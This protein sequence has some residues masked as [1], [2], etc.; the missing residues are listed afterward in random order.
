MLLILLIQFLL[1]TSVGQTWVANQATSFL[2]EKLNTV[3]SI[4]KVDISFFKF[5]S[6]DQI[7][8]EDLNQ[9]TLFYVQTIKAEIDFWDYSKDSLS[10]NFGNVE[11]QT[12]LYYLTQNQGDSITNITHLFAPLSSG[13]NSDGK[14]HLHIEANEIFVN[15]GRFIWNNYNEPEMDFG[16]NWDHIGL[17]SINGHFEDFEMINDSFNAYIHALSGKDVSGFE[18]TNLSGKAIF[19]S[20]LTQLEELSLI[21]QNSNIQ[22][23][24][25][26]N[27]DSITSYASFIDQVYMYYSIDSSII[28]MTDISYFAP[29][30]QGLDYELFVHGEEKG[31]VSDMKFNNIFISYGE[32]TI[33]DGRVFITGLPEIENT[34]FNCNFRNLS[35]NYNDLKS[36]KTYPFN[37][38]QTVTVPLF[39]KNAKGINF[40]GRFN[41]FYNDF[42]TYGTFTSA[43]GIVKT[44]LKL[45]QEE[46]GKILYDGKIKTNDFRLDALFNKNNLL[47][48][49]SI[50]IDVE[51]ENLDFN[52]MKLKMVGTASSFDFK[53][54]TYKN[55]KVNGEI[56]DK[57]LSGSLDIIDT[58]LRLDFDGA[59]NLKKD[60]PRYEFIAQVDHLKPKQ[61]NLMDRDTSASV[62][63]KVIFNFKG[64]NLDNVVGR[65][66]L[67]DFHFTEYDRKVDLKNVE[68]LA[69]NVGDDK[70]LS[71]KS[72]NIDL[73][74]NGQFNFNKISQSFNSIIYKWIPSAFSKKPVKPNEIQNFEM[75]M[76][77]KRF[78]GFSSIFIPQI[79]FESDL[80]IG[81][82][83][84]S[85]DEE[86][87]LNSNSSQL[88]IL[89]KPVHNFELGAS[90]T[91]DTLD[92]VVNSK[93]VNF[94]DSNF[95]ENVLFTASAHEDLINTHTSWNNS[96][97]ARDDSANIY[98]DILFTDPENF[99][100]NSRHSWIV[101]NDS[102]WEL[103]DSSEVI[104]QK[105]EYT[106]N[107]VLISQNDQHIRVNGA[108]S[109]NPEKSLKL[110]ID[111]LGLNVLNPLLNKYSINTEGTLRGTTTINDVYNEIGLTSENYF[112][113]LIFNDQYIGNGHILSK[114]NA[115]I[116][117][118][119]LMVDFK[120]EELDRLELLGTYI[121]K[122]KENQLNIDLTLDEFPVKIIEPFAEG[123]IDNVKGTISGESKIR[124]TIRHPLFDGRFKV[125]DIETR[126]IYL[127]ETLSITNEELFIR[128]TLIG[129]D[130]IVVSDQRGKKAQLNF[131]L[132]HNNFENIN[133]DLSCTSIDIFR[134]FNTER[135]DNDY[136]YGEVYLDPGSTVGIESDYEGNVSINAELTSG[137]QSF[138]TIPFYE[139]SEVSQR[140][141]IYF[142]DP[143]NTSDSLSLNNKK[144]P[145]AFGLNLDMNMNL[146]ENAEVQLIFDE[147]TN[148]NIRATGNG[149]IS[150]KI[151]ETDFNI[152]GTYEISKG[153]YLFTFSNIISKKFEIK[154]NSKLSWNGDPY[155]GISDIE[156]SYK[157]RTSLYDLGITLDSSKSRI[158]VEVVLNMTG[159]YMNPDLAFSFILPS[160]HED[161]ETLLN[162]L[163]DGEKNKQVFSLLILNKF[164][165][166]NGS[167]V[168]SGSSAIATNSTEVL[169]NQLSN[170]LSK[171]NDDVDVGLRYNPGET[172]TSSDGT[173]NTTAN[174][175][176]VALSTQLFNDRL[177]IETNFGF[178]DNTTNTTTTTN[179][180]IGEFTVSYKL[181]KKGN[182]VSKVFQ[183]SNELNPVL[184]NQAAYTQGIGLAYNEPF[185]SGSNLGCI[186]SNHFK[187][188]ENKRDCEEEYQQAQIEEHDENLIKITNKVKKSREKQRERNAKTKAR[189][190]KARRKKESR[191]S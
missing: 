191:N 53:N 91:P 29:T 72:D 113:S 158:P 102:L 94:S 156:A 11:I 130:A 168:S 46:T 125:K 126:V 154:P 144:D 98:L 133:Y 60:V 100:I 14:L 181:N 86:I 47:G 34:Y 30:L 186:L 153:Y 162:Q 21:T 79:S 155:Q 123:I 77:A 167:D 70:L 114:W 110:E 161:V 148:D 33:I 147:Y 141:Y 31:P 28:N 171:I 103:S 51:G 16:V 22:G 142:K 122:R 143:N 69:Y 49:A 157:V 10:L 170:W 149:N 57:I 59:I 58:N 18:L 137:P 117:G 23:L 35:S 104:K 132:F 12:P 88:N 139:E 48:K 129:A 26:Y 55:V 40:K 146:N 65:A 95:I 169:S 68:F 5:I 165:P 160:K 41:G 73:T 115:D 76:Y 54:Y 19:S 20:T 106:F 38:G 42:V 178:S 89:D 66:K 50:D 36:I 128:P 99:K 3:V 105:N 152:Y 134:A 52:T 166:I 151:T 189:E 78:S 6:L 90:L 37:T 187:K 175:V 8:I 121:P 17:N 163:D 112:T 9:D 127:N 15:Q 124:G 92:L 81:L 45:A 64:S 63:T 84:N 82:N 109:T 71:L 87:L 108:I 179:G 159:N 164:M 7:Y 176:E 1:W 111:S 150:L 62:S 184:I 183:R 174:E 116:E 75:T 4:E 32:Q 120:E 27:Y 83:Y 24:L 97:T 136:F 2:E 173:S 177:S 96:Q 80:F 39:L 101:L 188:K 119:D 56:S 74:I 180:F 138:V 43:N 107:N 140:D 190:E 25:T 145:G 13:E 135:E 93:V 118:F 67:E 131:S 44:D 172:S 61:L 185:K 85:E 182:V